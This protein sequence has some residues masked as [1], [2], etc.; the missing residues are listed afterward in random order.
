MV[1]V[2]PYGESII[3]N[4]FIRWPDTGHRMNVLGFDKLFKYAKPE[5]ITKVLTIPVIPLP[6]L[7]FAKITSHMDRHLTK[8]LLDI[9]YV[10]E[11]YEEVSISERRFDVTGEHDLSYEER[12]AYILGSDLRDLLSPREIE[13]VL[14]FLEE[15]SEEYS[16]HVQQLSHESGK[17]AEEILS[18][19]G[20]FFK[21]LHSKR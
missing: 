8:D 16:E 2:L 12:G 4:G 21:G 1:D 5:L 18:L 6:L 20:A 14:V 13:T 15:F 11:H 3:E 10:L 19:F 17:S 9:L 7:V